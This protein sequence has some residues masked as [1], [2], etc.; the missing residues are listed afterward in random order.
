MHEEKN[1]KNALPKFDSLEKIAEYFDLHSSEDL[2]WEPADLRIAKKEG[3]SS[4]DEQMVHVSI[5]LSK[6]DLSTLR[7]AA[8]KAGISQGNYLRLLIRKV[9][10]Q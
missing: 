4:E 3:F 1:E 6:Q 7:K 8:K 5:K 10:S 2:A 9:V